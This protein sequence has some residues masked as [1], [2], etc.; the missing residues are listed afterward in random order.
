MND[1]YVC[2]CSNVTGMG[3]R[4]IASIRAGGDLFFCLTVSV[5]VGSVGPAAGPQPAREAERGG[6]G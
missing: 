6:G 4:V 3:S 2:F 1:E 5:G